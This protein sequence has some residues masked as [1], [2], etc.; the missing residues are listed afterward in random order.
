MYFKDV[1]VICNSFN[2]ESKL[3]E[4]LTSL[5]RDSN[6]KIRTIM[7]SKINEVADKIDPSQHHLLINDYFSTL[8]D[9]SHIVIKFLYKMKLYKSNFTKNKY[10]Y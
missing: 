3:S 5:L 4:C 7:V 6:E 2:F 1:L 8:T 9:Q 10:I